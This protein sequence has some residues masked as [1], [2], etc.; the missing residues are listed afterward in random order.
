MERLFSMSAKLHVLNVR[1]LELGRMFDRGSN[2]R[3]TLANAIRC[4]RAA[5][6]LACDSYFG[7]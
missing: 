4:R 6:Q 1:D 3:K 5:Y 7:A 2:V